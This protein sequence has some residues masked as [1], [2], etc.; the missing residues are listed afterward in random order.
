MIR[1]SASPNDSLAGL[2]NETEQ[3]R[4][5]FY[6]G[7]ELL[8]DFSVIVCLL[9]CRSVLRI[10]EACIH[11]HCIRNLVKMQKESLNMVTVAN[12]V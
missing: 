4:E 6:L 10:N 8:K 2:P 7:K 11:Q 3:C 12:E 5:G 9:C 1:S